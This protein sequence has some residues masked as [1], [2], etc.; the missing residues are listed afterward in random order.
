M[1]AAIAAEKVELSNEFY[2]S[3]NHRESRCRCDPPRGR[4]AHPR[5]GALPMQRAFTDWYA[6]SGKRLDIIPQWCHTNGM[7]RVRVLGYRCERCG[8]QWVPRNVAKEPKVCPRCKSPYWDTPRQKNAGRR[9]KARGAR[10]TERPSRN[11][12]PKRLRR[13][14]ARIP[15]VGSLAGGSFRN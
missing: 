15:G 7:P 4:P 14:P 3:R 5:R 1:I 12:T 10:R 6:P 11:Q 8:H 9:A 13:G 2:S